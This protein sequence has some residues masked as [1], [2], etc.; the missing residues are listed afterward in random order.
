M[1]RVSKKTWNANVEKKKNIINEIKTENVPKDAEEED[2]NKLNTMFTDFFT[3]RSIKF[4]EFYDNYTEEARKINI[5]VHISRWVKSVIDDINSELNSGENIIYDDQ[6]DLINNLTD[7][8]FSKI[9]KDPKMY[10]IYE[11]AKR[12]DATQDEAQNLNKWGSIIDKINDKIKERNEYIKKQNFVSRPFS[13]LNDAMNTQIPSL[14][15][16]Y[17]IR[18]EYGEYT[19]KVALSKSIRKNIKE[20]VDEFTNKYQTHE[21]IIETVINNENNT[22]K[23]KEL[24]DELEKKIKKE[25]PINK[26]NSTYKNIMERFGDKEGERLVN[27]DSE[28]LGNK[29][30]GKMPSVKT[31]RKRKTRKTR[32]MRKTK[33]K[34]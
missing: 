17:N 13:Y 32:K 9:Y 22:Q 19:K 5:K 21:S 20:F 23:K 30:G 7:N 12:L 28:R 26:L 8:L 34:W 4:Y 18:F 27:N 16:F 3:N 33:N 25:E 11:E 15:N 31:R 24:I 10:E 2:N 29:D 14:N 1:G 6:K